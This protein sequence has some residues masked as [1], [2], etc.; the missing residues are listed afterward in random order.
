MVLNKELTLPRTENIGKGIINSFTN[1]K[2]IEVINLDV[3]RL[4]KEKINK[5]NINYTLK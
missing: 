4:P 1:F 2:R 5:V 3:K